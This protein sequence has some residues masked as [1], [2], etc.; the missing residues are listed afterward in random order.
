MKAYRFINKETGK[1]IVFRSNSYAQAV[2][3]LY[4]ILDRNIAEQYTFMKVLGN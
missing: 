1:S 4:A 3:D 2:N